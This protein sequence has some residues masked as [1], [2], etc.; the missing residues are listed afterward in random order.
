MTA[1]VGMAKQ[2]VTR[3]G[4]IDGCRDEPD[5]ENQTRLLNESFSRPEWVTAFLEEFLI[6]SEM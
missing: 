6:N 2:K 1:S 5:P 4:A 3:G